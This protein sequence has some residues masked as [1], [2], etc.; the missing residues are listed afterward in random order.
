MPNVI[1]VNLTK[2]L[3]MINTCHS[4]ITW[5]PHP[6]WQ[7]VGQKLPVGWTFQKNKIFWALP[8]RFISIVNYSCQIC[9]SWPREWVMR[10]H[11]LNLHWMTKWMTGRKSATRFL[12]INRFKKGEREMKPEMN[13]FC[14][15][16][17]IQI[18]EGESDLLA[19][20]SMKQRKV[21]SNQANWKQEIYFD[22]YLSQGNQQRKLS[23]FSSRL[24]TSGTWPSQVD[25]NEVSK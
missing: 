13:C 7:L 14:R 6:T 25:Q 17:L 3:E 1:W 16:N 8:V 9:S 19:S 20:N 18:G 22:S 4:F 15:W 11:I 21:V 12:R 10:M 2:E 5:R 23:E 24:F